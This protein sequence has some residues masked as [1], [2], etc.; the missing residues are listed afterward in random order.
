MSFKSENLITSNK[1]SL[2]SK[3]IVEDKMVAEKNELVSNIKKEFD[4]FKKKTDSDIK[5]IKSELRRQMKIL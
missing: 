3:R 4:E 1:S 2:K 5:D